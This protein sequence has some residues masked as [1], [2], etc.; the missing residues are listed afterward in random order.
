MNVDI[1]RLNKILYECQ[2]HIQRMDSS[3]RKMAPFM[4]LNGKNCLKLFDWF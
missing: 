1:E 4:P 2:K 3:S